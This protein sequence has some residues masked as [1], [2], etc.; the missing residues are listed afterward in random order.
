MDSYSIIIKPHVTEKT[1]N[2]IDKNNEITFVVKRDANKGQIKRAF[3]ELYEENN[4]EFIRDIIPKK[5]NMKNLT[6]DKLNLMFSH[7]NSVPRK[8]LGGKTPYEAFEFFYG[9][10]TLDKLN[11]QKIEKD[12]VTLQ[13]YL[14]KI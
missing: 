3:E 7:I 9:K 10:E 14:L 8:S 4:H 11:I 2:L 6:Q 13:P 5:Q 12:K 1:M